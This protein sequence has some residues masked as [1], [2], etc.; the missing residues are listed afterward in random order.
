MIWESFDDVD[1][2]E[3]SPR[4]IMESVT[5]VALPEGARCPD[6]QT[7][8]Q[9]LVE[10]KEQNNGLRLW[11]HEGEIPDPSAP[12]PL[13]RCHWIAV[14][15][16]T[17]I[18]NDPTYGHYCHHLKLRCDPGT[19]VRGVSDRIQMH[20]GLYYVL[21]A[22][23]PHEVQ[24]PSMGWNFGVCLDANEVLPLADALPRMIQF[25]MTAPILAADREILWTRT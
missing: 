2:A 7:L 18:H 19:S 23:A 3:F 14:R 16:S 4:A 11:G 9:A 20:R 21:D 8:W 6:N 12:R 10:G 17:C 15:A 1:T 25:A 13:N 5:R 24:S 22:H